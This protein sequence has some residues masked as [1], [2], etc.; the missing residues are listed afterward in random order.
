MLTLMVN[1]LL[2]GKDYLMNNIK[3]Y[4]LIDK[5]NWVWKHLVNLEL[6]FIP[7][8]HENISIEEHKYKVINR[9]YVVL[10]DKSYIE[11]YLK[12]IR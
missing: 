3:F 1:P 2:D 12:K 9:E 5:D 8:L 10:N 6:S 4:E 7:N 11:L